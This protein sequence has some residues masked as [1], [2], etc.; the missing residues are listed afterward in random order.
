MLCNYARPN[1]NK[2][3]E[4]F[5]Q[6]RTAEGKNGTIKPKGVTNSSEVPWSIENI[7]RHFQWTCSRNMDA[8]QT[9]V[10]CRV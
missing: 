6:I 1:Y 2:A 7:R 4:K 9:S 5:L 10:T 8:L 3:V